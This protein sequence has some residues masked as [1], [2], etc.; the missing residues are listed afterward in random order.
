MT[1]GALTSRKDARGIVTDYSFDLLD[2]MTGISY[3]ARPA[4]NVTQGY[5]T[6]RLGMLCS[7]SNNVSANTMSYDLAGRITGS[8]QT[9][10]GTAYNFSYVW[11]LAGG[12]DEVTYPSGNKTK[13]CS[14]VG[15]RAREVSRV[16]SGAMKSIVFVSL[17]ARLGPL[18]AV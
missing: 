8:T 14:D 3:P 13:S 11:N 12:L 17:A 6:C 7:V 4:G 15:S 2:R 18:L 16:K 5:D 10:G 1:I 9:T